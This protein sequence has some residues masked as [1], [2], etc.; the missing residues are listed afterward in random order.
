V[1]VKV[2]TVGAE[3]VGRSSR[4]SGVVEARRRVAL[5]SETSGR[6]LRLGAEEFQSVEAKQV[7]VEVDPLLAIVAVERAEAA[8]ARAQ[9]QLALARD[10]RSR[11]ESLATRDAASLSRRD[12][13]VNAERVAAA[14]LREARANRSEAHDQRSKKTIR[15]PFSGVLQHFP[16]E[17]GGTLRQGE[18]VAELLDLETARIALGV[19]DREVVGMQAGETVQ[20]ELEA[21]PGERFSGTV[22]HVAA[23]A[24]ATTLKFPVELELANPGRRILPGMVARVTLE[25]ADARP[26]R[27][28]P[29]DA[30][31]E[32]FGVRFVYVV[33]E[34]QGLPVARQ[35]NVEL[36]DIPF[37]PGLVELVSGVADGERV[38]TSG[39]REL[40]DGAHVRIDD[41]DGVANVGA[42]E[43]GT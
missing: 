19:T 8:V 23:A 33:G 39:I 34:E 18:T 22:L 15:A 11:W 25:L 16:V 2:L 10:E 20:V 28:L 13:A 30:A 21:W 43:S 24:D 27:A 4:F 37:R 17:V 41:R 5:V 12:Q 6:V 29:R 7:L 1:P 3:A 35:R 14:N 42:E 38:A 31:I 32:S 9:S 26:L 40:S 36:R